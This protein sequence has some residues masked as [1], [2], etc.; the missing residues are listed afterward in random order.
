MP[1]SD[2]QRV[3]DQ[4]RQVYG[5]RKAWKQLQREDVA[6]ARCTMARL[7]RRLDLQGARRCRRVCTMM[8]DLGQPSPLDRVRRNLHADR[9]DQL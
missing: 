4:S 5:V 6:V 1:L 2:I 7:M 3:F 8:P 9:S